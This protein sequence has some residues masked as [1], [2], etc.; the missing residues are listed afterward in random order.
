MLCCARCDPEMFDFATPW[1]SIIAL[2]R[3]NG[4]SISPM[5]TIES[6][7]SKPARY[8][9]IP[10]KQ[11]IYSTA[12]RKAQQPDQM[13]R[14]TTKSPCTTTIA[15]RPQGCRK[16]CSKARR[17]TPPIP[18]AEAEGSLDVVEGVDLL[19]EDGEQVAGVLEV[20]AVRGWG[21]AFLPKRLNEQKP[22][23]R[24][25]QSSRCRYRCH[26]H[27]HSRCR[28]R[29]QSCRHFHCRYHCY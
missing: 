20:A 6:E 26:C 9:S 7:P 4:L 21:G 5:Y 11:I 22:S 23:L 29:S 25:I 18:R 12:I 8:A 24:G 16:K 17:I 10:R 3:N 27:C 1:S 28:C 13:Y 15:T 14:P 2:K 19:K